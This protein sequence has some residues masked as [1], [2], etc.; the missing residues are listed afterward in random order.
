MVH[1]LGSPGAFG[2]CNEPISPAGGRGGPHPNPAA[3]ET[4]GFGGFLA[5]AC[6]LD[7][8]RSVSDVLRVTQAAALMLSRVLFLW[9]I[10][11]GGG[12]FGGPLPSVLLAPPQGTVARPR[13]PSAAC[14]SV[15]TSPP[16]R[17]KVWPLHPS[18]GIAKG[19]S[20]QEVQLKVVS[21][22]WLSPVLV[23]KYLRH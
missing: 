12:R 13:L 14:R 23:E 9:W 4:A 10:W 6:V 2:S 18:V 20:E 1:L 7:V 3:R 17:L 15:S 8:V 11:E 16:R 21:S 22:T 5:A 19:T